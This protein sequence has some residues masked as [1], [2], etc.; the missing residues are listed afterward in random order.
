MNYYIADCHFGDDQVI[1][2]S[3]RPFHSLEEMDRTMV[4]NWNKVVG[5]YDDVYILG[6]LISRTKAPLSYLKQ[7]KGR[8]HL[9]CGNH[10][11]SMLKDPACRDYFVE[12]ANYMVVED[13]KHRLVLFHYPLLEWDGYYYGTWHLYGHIHNHSSHNQE[14]AKSLFKA[15]N[16]GADVVGFKPRTFDELVAINKK[17]RDREKR[18][19]GSV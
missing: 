7:L 8:L 4:Q 2:Y 13:H 17:D 18:P 3:H 14:K 16:C 10:D 11:A 15:L 19:E 6:D 9:V 12:V 5:D 1:A